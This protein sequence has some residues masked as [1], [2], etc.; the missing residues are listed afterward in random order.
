MN[1][2]INEQVFDSFPI[3]ESNRLLFRNFNNN[4]AVFLFKIRSHPAVIR[5]LDTFPQKQQ[6]EA[7]A[8][9]KNNWKSFEQ[10]TGLNWAIVE[11]ENQQ[12]IGYFGFWRLIK[13]HSRAEMGY[14]LHPD[15]WRKGYMNETLQ[16]MI[17]FAFLQLCVHS[18]EANVNPNNKASIALLKRNGF[19]QEAYFKEDY[20]FNGKFVDSMIFSLLESAITQ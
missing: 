18:L 11:K 16:I 13:A 19:V 9:I 8:L 15:Y 17:N 12:F 14:A 3:L 4:D 5:Y 7:T 10:K 2:K 1:I 6:S 20:F